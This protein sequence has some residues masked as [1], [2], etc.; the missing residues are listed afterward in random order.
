M[1]DAPA[2]ESSLR[3]RL[4]F[5]VPRA[6]TPPHGVRA[7]LG[8]YLRYR[9]VDDTRARAFIWSGAD[10]QRADRAALR[11]AFRAHCRGCQDWETDL[12]AADVEA[13]VR[14]RESTNLLNLACLPRY[15][16]SRFI[17]APSAPPR[18]DTAG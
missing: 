3:E 14:V 4:Q 16:P 2:T 13:F 10:L 8:A 11:D 18:G 15:T 9:G 7:W 1:S 17:H 12:M 6:E 5:H